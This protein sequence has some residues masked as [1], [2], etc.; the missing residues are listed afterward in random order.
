M[1]LNLRL[2][3]YTDDVENKII[4]ANDPS[5]MLLTPSHTPSLSMLF[6]GESES[7]LLYVVGIASIAE[8]IDELKVAK[9]TSLLSLVPIAEV[10]EDSEEHVY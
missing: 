4:I 2:S 6:G 1:C 9:P 7:L 8:G 5:T 10:D 3:T